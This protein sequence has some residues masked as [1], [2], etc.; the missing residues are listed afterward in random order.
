MSVYGTIV[1]Y[2]RFAVHDGDGIRTTLFLKG[3]PLACLWCHNP[4]GISYKPQLAYIPHK[5]INCGECSVCPTEAHVFDGSGHIFKR[6]K[7]T[8]CGQCSDVCLGEALTLYGKRITAEEAAETLLIDKDFFL[9]SGGGVTLSGGEPL[10]QPEFTKEVFRLVKE[11]GVSTAL[12]TCGYAPRKALETVL[13]YTDKVL[14]DMKTANSKTHEK[15]TGKPN[16]LIHDNLKYINEIGIP[17]EI[18]I[19]FVPDINDGEIDGIADIL[20]PLRSV[21]AVRVLAYHGYAGTKYESLGE[22][23]KGA[24]LVPPTKEQLSKA[25]ETLKKRGLSV[26]LPD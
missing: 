1:E 6:E 4:E 13:P 21:T 12:D 24:H 16:E 10:M 3:C 14:F 20:A 17:I 23:Y 15:Y 26:I 5:C 2:K 22:T 25:G 19:P 11:Q 9:S 7:C 18:R 8:A